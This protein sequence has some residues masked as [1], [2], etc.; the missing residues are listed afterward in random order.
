MLWRFGTRPLRRRLWFPAFAYS[1][2]GFGLMCLVRDT[3]GVPNVWLNKRPIVRF[4]G[5]R[6]LPAF[7]FGIELR[8]EDLRLPDP[9]KVAIE[10]GRGQPPCARV[11]LSD[12]RHGKDMSHEDVIR[13]LSMLEHH[14]GTLVILPGTQPPLLHEVAHALPSCGVARINFL[15]IQFTERCVA[16][17]LVGVLDLF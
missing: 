14:R 11:A 10:S 2:Q 4:H 9:R 16:V 12:R 5:P 8:A 3:V 13:S 17:V 15:P 7:G 1:L 6:R